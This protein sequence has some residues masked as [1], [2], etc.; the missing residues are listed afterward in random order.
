M[1]KNCSVCNFDYKVQP[2]RYET[3]KFC[4]YNCYWGRSELLK[5]KRCSVCKNFYSINV[6]QKKNRG[7]DSRCKGCKKKEWNNWSRRNDTKN[8]FRMYEWNSKKVDR[9]FC[10]T[11]EDFEKYVTDNP[12]HYCNNKERRLGLDRIDSGV[13]YIKS[14]IVPCCYL[15]NRAKSD[16]SAKDF[17]KLCKD[18]TENEP[19]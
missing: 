2:Y 16:M 13:G 4:S 6:F 7:W 3:S 18:I 9:E 5:E 14:N 19:T 10:I 17:I 11:L 15:C 12:C 8:R 1:I